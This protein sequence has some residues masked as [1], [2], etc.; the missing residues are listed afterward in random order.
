[1]TWNLTGRTSNDAASGPGIGL[2]AGREAPGLGEG[3]DKEALS[4]AEA[5][6]VANGV[7][8]PCQLVVEGEVSQF[9]DKPGYKAAYF[10]LSD[11]SATMSCLMWRERYR[12]SGV[13]LRQ[14]MRIRLTGHFN[15]YAK[16]GRLSFEVSKLEEAGEGDLRQKV[17]RLA[18]R[19]AE[20]GL[21]ADARKRPIPAFCERV[22]VV[23]SPRGK[24]VH[25]VIRTLRRRNPLVELLV[26]GVP[27]EGAT[28][29]AQM[30]EALTVAAAARPDVILLV[31]GGGSYEDLMPFNDEGLA[32]AVAACPVPVV[33]GIGHEPDTT[34]CDLASDRRASTPTAAAESVAPSKDELAASLGHQLT[35]LSAPV[36][37]L[38]AQAQR[39]LDLLAARPVLANP[40]RGFTEPRQHE[41]DRA[42]D[43][44]LRVGTGVVGPRARELNLAG[45]RLGRV[46]PA[47]TDGRSRALA[48]RAGRLEALSPLAVIARGYALAFDGQG[49]VMR[50]VSQALPSAP[51]SVRL[52]DGLIDAQVTAITSDAGDTINKED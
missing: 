7:L 11:G 48:E 22:A 46:A 28:A 21:L 33:T 25:D 14:G 44:L 24:V 52:A 42:C 34:I 5:V 19:L 38:L 47:L 12:A 2:S 4:V 6:A 17:A 18:R 39:T 36:G 23:T 15:I 20:E 49:H 51:I 16:N 35:R 50:S 1:M 40:V 3:P 41:L 32:R 27:V 45:D 30:A 37:S 29:P 43:R 31:R 13:V 9:N 26:C 10:D 8:K